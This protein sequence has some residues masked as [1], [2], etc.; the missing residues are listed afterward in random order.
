MLTIEK[1]CV[2]DDYKF[3][4]LFLVFCVAGGLWSHFF[5]FLFISSIHNGPQ[6]GYSS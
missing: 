4:D 5:L 3:V 6:E 1:Y 2:L